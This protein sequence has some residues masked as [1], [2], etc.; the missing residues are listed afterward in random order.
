MKGLSKLRKAY[1]NSPIIGYL[2]IKSLK[3]KIV[4]LTEIISTYKIDILC[5]DETKLDT[6]FPDS[7]FKIDGYQ[8][9]LFRNNRDSKGAGKIV[10]VQ[11]SIVAKRLSHC[12]SWSIESICTELTISKRK[13][14]ILFA[15]RPPNLKKGE[16][17]KEISNTLSKALK[18]YDNIVLA[19]DLNI[20]LLDPS[21]D[22]SNHLPVLLDAF[23]LRNLVKE[24]TCFMSDKGSLID[25][26]LTNKARSFHKT[27]GF[28][29]GIRVPL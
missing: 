20:D 9:P 13:W 8:F 25:V 17:L 6:S 18:C 15:Y 16:F 4:C 10:F 11:E 12:E 23:N 26:I 19:G 21:K 3:E 14:C 27:Q 22:T 28:V 7:Q 24:S 29:T 2:N 1:L 5:I